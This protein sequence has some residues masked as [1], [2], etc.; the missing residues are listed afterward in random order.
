MARIDAT[1]VTSNVMWRFIERFGA[2][3]ISLCVSLILARLLGPD[4]YGTVAIVVA[5]MAILQIFVDSGLGNALVQKKNVENDDY[6]T[7]FVFNT[8]M[9]FGLYGILFLVAPYIAQIYEI[10]ELTVLVRVLGIN[11]V[12]SGVRNVQQ[13]YISRNMLAKKF[14][15]VTIGGTIVSA[16]VGVA[17]AFLGYG[18][19]ALVAQNLVSATFSLVM[20]WITL[21]WKPIFKFSFVRFKQLF[22]FGWKLL[23]SALLD[24]GYNELC[25]LLIGGV[26]S[27]TDLG[28]YTNGQKIP[29]L[30][31]SNINTSIT[32]VLFPALSEIQDDKNMLK[33]LMQRGMKI[34]SYIIWPMLFGL[35]ACAEPLVR[36]LLTEKWLPAVPYMQIFCLTLGMYP[37]HTANLEAIKAM[38]RSDLF[39]KLEIVKKVIAI[40][41]LLTVLRKSVM[42]FALCG[43][44]STVLSAVINSFPNWRLLKYNGWEQLRDVLPPFLLSAVMAVVVMQF[45]R[46][47]TNDILLLCIQVPVGVVIYVLSSWIFKMDSFMYLLCFAKNMIASRKRKI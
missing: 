39:L 24:T 6:S 37:I 8:I 36:L 16:A 3:L 13:A 4:D 1:T 42:A 12:L 7:V 26:Y 33:R 40:V 19:W 9:C 43:I 45:S 32:S 29:N 18:V 44:V 47:I 28:Y 21:D 11:L 35:M 10:P 31:I 15:F 20:L 22:G 25:N 27:S 41:L 14:F 17:M 2:Q 30:V 38:G 34:S 5:I 46:F 23:I